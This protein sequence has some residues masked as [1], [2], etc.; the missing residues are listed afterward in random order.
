MDMLPPGAPD[1]PN[2]IMTN[3]SKISNAK[4]PDGI[5]SSPVKAYSLKI[6]NFYS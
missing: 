6:L 1:N 5:I 3:F 4:F 2:N